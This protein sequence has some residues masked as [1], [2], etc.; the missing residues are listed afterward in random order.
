V[1]LALNTDVLVHWAMEGAPRHSAVRRLLTRE[2]RQ[3]NA[4]LGLTP[5]VVLEF[6]HVVTD[7]KRFEH[8]ME[9]AEAQGVAD[10]L[11]GSPEAE[12]LLPVASVVPRT[13]ELLRDLRLGRRR[14]LDTAL[15]ATLEAAGVR[16]LA[17]LNGDDYEAF[18]FIEVVTP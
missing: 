1:I 4:R 13:I 18:D 10:A 17:T 11:W 16:R 14:I 12:H 2:V 8:A 15:A 7:P 9:M 3:Q 5:Q 6:L